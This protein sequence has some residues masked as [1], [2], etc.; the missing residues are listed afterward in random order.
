MNTSLEDY[1]KQHDSE[2]YLKDVITGYGIE[3]LDRLKVE[4]K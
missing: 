4:G 2:Y 3:G 1:L